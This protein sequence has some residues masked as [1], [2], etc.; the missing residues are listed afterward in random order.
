MNVAS[1]LLLL[2]LL[3]TLKHLQCVKGNLIETCSLSVYQYQAKI[4]LPCESSLV[5][6]FLA[7]LLLQGYA[8]S[9]Q[10]LHSIPEAFALKETWSC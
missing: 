6:A 4:P 10:G 7:V 1:K 9:F 3:L 5:S 2:L 8:I